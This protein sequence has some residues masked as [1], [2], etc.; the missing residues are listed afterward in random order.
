MEEN[1]E[2]KLSPR[3]ISFNSPNPAFFGYRRAGF[4]LFISPR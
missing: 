3:K 2:Y 4:G 1:G